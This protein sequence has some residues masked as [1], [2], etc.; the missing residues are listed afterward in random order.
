MRSGIFLIAGLLAFSFP[1]I[2]SD[3]IR[4]TGVREDGIDPDLLPEKEYNSWIA[5]DKAFEPEKTRTLSSDDPPPLSLNQTSIIVSDDGFGDSRVPNIPSFL[6][7]PNGKYIWTGRQ[8]GGQIQAAARFKFDLSSIPRSVA[9]VDAK[10]RSWVNSAAGG[11]VRVDKT[12]LAPADDN[13][14]AATLTWNYIQSNP[15]GA[16][17]AKKY[18]PTKMFVWQ[19]IGSRELTVVVN[20]ENKTDRILSLE[21]DSPIGSFTYWRDFENREYFDTHEARL[22]LELQSNWD[23]SVESIDNP[24]IN[25][26]G[27]MAPGIPFTP[28]V[29]VRNKGA[30]P[31]NDAEVTLNITGDPPAPVSEILTTGF[32]GSMEEMEMSFSSFTPGAE[33]ASYAMA[34]TAVITDPT[35]HDPDDNPINN[36]KGGDFYSWLDK[37]DVGCVYTT[38]PPNI[39][40]NVNIT[41]GE[42][43]GAISL[44]ISDIHGKSTGSGMTDQGPNPPGSAVLYAMNDDEYL[45]LGI[46]TKDPTDT[47]FDQDLFIFDDDHNHLFSLTNPGKAFMQINNYQGEIVYRSIPSYSSTY[48]PAGVFSSVDL[49]TSGLEYEL[50]IPFGYLEPPDSTGTRIYGTHIMTWDYDTEVYGWFPSTMPGL[51]WI[52]PSEYGHICVTSSAPE[53]V[54]NDGEGAS[55]LTELENPISFTLSQPYPNPSKGDVEIQYAIPSESPV[56]LKVYDL[57]GRQVATLVDG[58]VEAGIHTVKFNTLD[59]TSGIY[60]YRLRAGNFTQTRKLVVMR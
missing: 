18:L 10:F 21:L 12:E 27:L 17:V 11:D 60:F 57:S 31:I 2:G 13:W 56:T 53:L 51:L 40:G 59:L 41:G 24:I 26:F 34:I 15:A 22:I 25:T 39:D 52:L 9:I 49:Q 30:N 38:T 29:T 45:Y 1:L 28:K 4:D 35:G 47:F 20:N 3:K 42:W 16:T 5:P 58:R 19:D 6:N 50:S 36:S 14:S 54:S 55:I 33:P 32:M 37:F 44:D 23:L 46:K 7:Y 48:N 43:V 8:A